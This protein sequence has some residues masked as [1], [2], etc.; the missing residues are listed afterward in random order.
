MAVSTGRIPVYLRIGDG[1]EFEVGAFEPK[2][3]TETGVVTLHAEVDR[4]AVAAAL[5]RAADLLDPPGVRT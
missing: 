5:R 3:T 4:P 2:T 1:D